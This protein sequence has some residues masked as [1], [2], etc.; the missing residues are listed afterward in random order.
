MCH[1]KFL[2]DRLSTA[3]VGVPMHVFLLAIYV[4]LATLF[5]A[6]AACLRLVFSRQFHQSDELYTITQH[7]VQN[8]DSESVSFHGAPSLT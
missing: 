3:V 6:S 7:T 4:I 2:G 1:G 5:F 8:A